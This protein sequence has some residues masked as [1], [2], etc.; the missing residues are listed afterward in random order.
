MNTFKAKK[1]VPSIL[2]ILAAICI[3]IF[4]IWAFSLHGTGGL[5]HVNG[6]F[7]L[8]FQILGC[9]G[10][11]LAIMGT[12]Y[13]LFYSRLKRSAINILAALL[14]TCSVPGLLVPT[15]AYLYTSGSF[16]GG[17]GDTS[18]QL[19]IS[20]KCGCYGIPDLAL[21]FNSAQASYNT[22]VWGTAENLVT[23][24]EDK[25]LRQHIFIMSDLE[26]LTNYSYRVNDGIVYNFTTP[27]DTSLRIAIGSDAHFGAGDNRMDLTTA[28]LQ[29]IAE[30]NNKFD[31]MFML[32]DLIEYGFNANQWAEAFN[33]VSL[34]SSS[35]PI[36]YALGNHDSIFA[37]LNNYKNFAS[38][39]EINTVSGSQLWYRIDIGSIHFLFLDIEWSAESYTA[40]QAA[41]LE[42]QLQEI[43]RNDW[44]IVLGHG[45]YFS[46]GATQTCRDWFDNLET[47]TPLTPLFEKYGVDLVFSG[48][49]HHMELLQNNGVTYVICGA[50][51]GAHDHIRT[52]TSPTS[53]WYQQAQY[54]FVDVNI[55]SHQC[56]LFFRDSDN[57]ILNT[58]TIWK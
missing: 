2:A 42:S 8:L 18:P 40:A 48:H 35:I 26:P 6:L 30:P 15:F 25:A 20:D 11:A 24:R 32:G 7:R 58:I 46:S 34:T 9:F 55:D 13:L 37:G 49:N 28:M 5:F 44:K 23:I 57:L 53:L 36:R 29:I 3:T 54:G 52:Y 47:I 17:I 22:L 27:S 12:G 43:P 1:F 45:Y 41:W 31:Y 38:P 21:T 19:L 16:S 39:K 14:I 50:F 51:G 10:I 33:T 4:I 56:S